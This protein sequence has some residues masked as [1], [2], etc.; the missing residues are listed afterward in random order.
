MCV[1]GE[2]ACVNN[3]REKYALLDNAVTICFGYKRMSC[4]KRFS[5]WF[6]FLLERFRRFDFFFNI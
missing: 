5:S 6:S 2:H 4:G 1:Y 3:F